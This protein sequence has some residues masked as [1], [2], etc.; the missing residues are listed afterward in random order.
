MTSLAALLP[1]FFSERLQKQRQVSAHTIAA[2]RDTFRLLVGFAQQQLKKQPVDLMMSDL[3]PALIA[4]FLEH[5]ESERKNT[6]R[7]SNLRLAA[8]R[9]FFRYVALQEPSL[10]LQAQRILAMPQK[11]FDRAIVTFLT[12][13]EIESLLAAPDRTTWIGRRDATLLLLLVQTGLRVSEL[14]GLKLDDLNLS[15]GAHIRCY[16]KGRKERCTPLTRQTIA[17]LSDWIKQ[18]HLQPKDPLFKSRRGTILSR[19]AVERLVASNAQRARV[20][21]PS[22]QEKRVTPHVLRHTTAVHLWLAPLF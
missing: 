6:P 15:A 4:A 3:D 13:P 14:I 8:I 2:Y 16:G 10:L 20:M 5:L 9:S 18:E 12:T 19:D 7:T 17:S 22:L 21:C 1:S 11:R